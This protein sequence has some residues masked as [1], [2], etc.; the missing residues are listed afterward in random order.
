[1]FHLK[2]INHLIPM[3]YPILF[4][5]AATNPEMYLNLSFAICMLVF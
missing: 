4:I 3:Q 5:L 2:L 1:M